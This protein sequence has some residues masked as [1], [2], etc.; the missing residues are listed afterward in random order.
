MLAKSV[1]SGGR[2]GAALPATTLAGRDEQ[3]SL[4]TSRWVT[5]RL[6]TETYAINVLSVQ[7]VLKDT[8]VTPV[9]GAPHYVL[10]I[11]NLRGNVVSVV[12]ARM[13]FGLPDI[14]V[15]DLTR[16]VMVEHGTQSIG[17]M[18]DAVAEVVDIEAGEVVSTGGPGEDGSR[19]IEGTVTR[20]ESLIIL[21]D[22]DSLLK[23]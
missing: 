2:L 9:P 11:L 19:H 23:H 4:D 20:G 22:L 13:R 1:E 16:I 5:F 14:D 8:K 15:T 21:V 6:D 10:G 17:L 18:V 12:N 7:E 3:V